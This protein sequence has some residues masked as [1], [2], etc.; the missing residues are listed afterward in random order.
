[1][2]A[3]FKNSFLYLRGMVMYGGFWRRVL[4][5]IIDGIPL[6]IVSMVLTLGFSPVNSF[7]ANLVV[8]WLYYAGF[9]SSSYQATWGKQA[10]GMKVTDLKGK[11]IS[12]GQASG[13]HFAK[14]L[15]MLILFIGFLMVAFTEKKQGL[16]D[17]LAGT[18]VIKA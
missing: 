1:M 11:R 3:R 2:S 7:F 14:Y 5:S 16:H 8:G 10:L 13:R 18:L 17:Q 15:S 9:E 12:F 4:A 6:M